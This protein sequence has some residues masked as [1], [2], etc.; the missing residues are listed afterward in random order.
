MVGSVKCLVEGK[1]ELARE[2]W[3]TAGVEAGI[4]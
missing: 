2:I 4:A 1:A 3:E